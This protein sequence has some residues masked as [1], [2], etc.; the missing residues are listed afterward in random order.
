MSSEC[1]QVAVKWGSGGIGQSVVHEPK[2]NKCHSRNCSR[3]G[4][5][6]AARLAI[7]NV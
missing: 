2:A 3:T 1:R 5:N 4:Q 7:R 6:S